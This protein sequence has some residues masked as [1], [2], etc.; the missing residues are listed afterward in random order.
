[1]EC[2]LTRADSYSLRL[3]LLEKIEKECEQ[4]EYPAFEIEFQ[5]VYPPRRYVVI[6]GWL[7]DHYAGL[8]RRE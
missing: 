1:M 7:Y 3:D 2:K 5:G 4:G 8:E 6:P